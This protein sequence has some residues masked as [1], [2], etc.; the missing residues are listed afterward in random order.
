MSGFMQKITRFLEANVEWI[1]LLIAVGYLGWT[2]W[3][4][5]VNN[6][7]SRELGGTAVSPAN[8]D[9]FIDTH[10]AEHLRQITQPGDVPSFSVKDF[11]QNLDKW[12]RLE[13]ENPQ[14]L[15]GGDF[16]FSPF[17]VNTVAGLGH[18]LGIPVEQLPKPPAPQPILT[19]AGLDT[20]A[21]PGASNAQPAS[22][23]GGKDVRLVVVG[24]TIPWSQLYDQ[25]NKAFGPPKPGQQPRLSPAEFQVVAVTAERWEKVGDNWVQDSDSMHLINGSDLPPYPAPGNRQQASDYMLALNKDPNTVVAPT[26][27]TVVAGAT[28]KDPLQYLPGVSNQPGGGAP[29][30]SGA[31]NGNGVEHWRTA[32]TSD[33]SG[34]VYAQYGGGPGGPP[35]GFGGP[36]GGGFR[37][38]PVPEPQEQPQPQPQATAIPPA[39]GTVNPK[40][41]YVDPNAVITPTPISALKQNNLIGMPEKSPDLFIYIIDTSA[42]PGR[43]YRYR[44]SYKAYNPLYN[45][46]PQRVAANKVQWTNQFDLESAMSDFSP[47]ILVPTQTYCYCGTPQ[48]HGT[49]YPFDVFTWSAGKWQKETFNV[50][51]GDP[52]GGADGGVD[53]STGY[54]FVDRQLDRNNKTHIYLVDQQ[55]TVVLAKDADSPEYKQ[56]NQWMTQQSGAPQ[57]PQTPGGP[58]T[59][60]GGYPPG[61]F[62]PPPGGPPPGGPGGP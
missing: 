7:V 10:A 30:Q 50:D 31:N 36:P 40:V 35:G 3:T 48:G 60:P 23:A 49:T 20:L 14:E 2:V 51:V 46:P 55:G 4:Y 34:T 22:A 32:N 18:A 1:A 12:I 61:G 8:V 58:M 24:F 28:W 41:V 25:W 53:Y 47:E 62:A 59:P 27:P 9:N 45:K 15:A 43:T 37:R 16:D 6:P 57:S 56:S 13:P 39:E 11:G 21:A 33:L 54:T 29:D 44:I 5:L 42:Q 17:D 26:I 38:P 52:I 19:A